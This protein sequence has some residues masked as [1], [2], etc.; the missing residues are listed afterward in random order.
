MVKMTEAEKRRAE[1]KGGPFS[2]F[3][4][5]SPGKGPLLTD[6]S[7]IE[8]LVRQFLSEV[9]DIR[10]AY[11]GGQIEGPECPALIK[12][13]AARYA[14]IF[15]GGDETYSFTNWNSQERLGAF[16]A[17]ILDVDAGEAMLAFFLR[18]ASDF[19]THAVV[20]FEDDKID[21]ETT[22]FRMEV[23]IEDATFA[24]RG[25]HNSPLDED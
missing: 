24:L 17:G 9:L 16:L 25:L 1:D 19:I 13:A 15:A 18:V 6:P 14:N 20:P 11:N 22:T 12:A 21:M 23:T 10:K 7:I 5:P 2:G 4:V 3:D 8:G